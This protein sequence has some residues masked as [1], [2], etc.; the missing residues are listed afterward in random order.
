LELGLSASHSL[1]WS[2][3]LLGAAILLQGTLAGNR[4]RRLARRVTGQPTERIVFVAGAFAIVVA[5]MLITNAFGA[6]PGAQQG[7]YVAGVLSLFL[8]AAVPLSLFLAALG[9]DQ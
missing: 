8:L 1:S 9:S 7:W 5:L 4:D 6:M 2:S 3:G